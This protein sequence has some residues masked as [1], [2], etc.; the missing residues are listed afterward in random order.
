[1]PFRSVVLFQQG[2]AREIA[3]QGADLKLAY[4]V[5]LDAQRRRNGPRKSG[6]V[7]D[8]MQEGGAP[9]RPGIG[10]R[11]GSLGGVENELH[12]AI[13]DGID[14]V[15]AAFQLLVDLGAGDPPLTQIPL[16]A[17]GGNNLE[18]EVG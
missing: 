13:L 8:F 5:G 1:V 17:G 16:R 15:R 18:S 14:D 11:L 6:V 2:F 4:Q 12:L 9:Q 7:R 3:L 10:Q